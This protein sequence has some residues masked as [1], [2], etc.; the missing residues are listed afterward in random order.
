MANNMC[1]VCGFPGLLEPAYNA[2]GAPSY[3]I[4]PCCG[5]EFG[6][7]DLSEGVSHADYREKWIA[8]GAQWFDPEQKP[9]D[10]DLQAQLA[11]LNR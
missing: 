5:F 4:C 7:D 3:E 2:D 11:N 10:W 8:E 6:F 1:P 9:A